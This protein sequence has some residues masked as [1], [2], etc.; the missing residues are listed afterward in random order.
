VISVNGE[1]STVAPG[2]TVAALLVELEAPDRGVAVAI[3][4]EVVPR[5]AWG[6]TP[7]G[8]DARVEVVMAVQGG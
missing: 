4:G 2:T 6:R 5:G 1:P 7:I 3:D 8:D